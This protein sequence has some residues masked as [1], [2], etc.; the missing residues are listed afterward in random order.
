MTYYYW[1]QPDHLDQYWT[2]TIEVYLYLLYNPSERRQLLHEIT[3]KHPGT[4][5]ILCHRLAQ[6]ILIY[7]GQGDAILVRTLIHLLQFRGIQ[8]SPQAA[9]YF[10]KGDISGK[11]KSIHCP[12]KDTHRY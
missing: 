11:T 6:N 7:P 5:V 8:T 4:P 3:L 9:M 12:F 10:G 2:T 1:S